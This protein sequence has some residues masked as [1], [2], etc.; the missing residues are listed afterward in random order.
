MPYLEQGRLIKDNLKEIIKDDIN[1][2]TYFEETFLFEPDQILNKLELTH[3]ANNK[4]QEEMQIEELSQPQKKVK[5]DNPPL[6]RKEYET[7]KVKEQNRAKVPPAA[8]TI[9]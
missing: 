4:I 1:L 2:R 6:Q 9:N 8:L 5:R 7:E 3:L